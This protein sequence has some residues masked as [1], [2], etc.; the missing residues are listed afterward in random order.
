[1]RNLPA[2]LVLL[3][4]VVPVLPAEAQVEI[5]HK[6]V[7]CIVAGKFP[8]M[9]ACFTPAASL[10]QARVYFRPE[11]TPSW[12]YVDM[13][14]D[15]PCWAGVLPKPS[16]KLLQKKI[17]YYVEAQDKSFTSGRTAEYAP[18]VVASERE[19][20]KDV[21]VAPISATGP[22]AVFPA[23]PAGFAASSAAIGAG[24]VA[25]GVAGVGAAT[26]GVVAATGGN[27]TTTTLGA[28]TTTTTA[29]AATT[30]TTTT[31]TTTPSSNKPPFAVLTTNPD[32]P[33]GKT[34]LTVT[35][36]MCGSS[37]PEGKPLSF[38]FDFGDGAN[39][40]GT[41]SVSHSYTA[42]SFR[43]AVGDTSYSFQ[44]CVVDDHNASACRTRTVV[45]I[46]PV[47]GTPV[48]SLGNPPE[49]SCTAGFPP[50]A[51]SADA[52]ASDPSGL[53]KVD[54]VAIRTNAV[55]DSSTGVC[56]PGSPV[57][58]DD[59]Q[60]STSAPYA[61]TLALN[62][63]PDS[64]FHCYQIKAVA[65]NVCGN[66]AL[67]FHN[68][69]YEGFFGCGVGLRGQQKGLAPLALTSD[70]TRGMR[71]QVMV[72]GSSGFYTG[73]GRSSGTAEVHSGENRLEATVVET[74]GRAGLWKLQLGSA[75][76]KGAAC[77]WSR[78][79]SCCWAPTRSRSA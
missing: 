77:A 44:G 11:G 71:I 40:A 35:F 18:L 32:P 22:A 29:P 33:Q 21:P 16:K 49:G 19:C 74:A 20:K 61:A 72:N 57:V 27:D 51:V 25:L 7:G 38:Y 70:L 14:S 68:I 75:G 42:S 50:V 52:T 48:V 79:R 6:A 69:T 65:T 78:V 73:E 4:A 66:S 31:T 3:A 9:N 13:K 30:T 56:G 62:P 39:A 10:A 5:D 43:A 64:L 17:E 8:K 67:D 76:L 1:M 2:S 41:C 47:C 60:T 63:P 23:I 15:T 34:P 59:T 37:D 53:Q 54:F 55:P 26:A 58:T 12:Y 46:V 24:T 36:D 28:G 45:V